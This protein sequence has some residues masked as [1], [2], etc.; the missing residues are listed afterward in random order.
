MKENIGDLKGNLH[1]TQ[2]LFR[3]CD[4]KVYKVL[5]REGRVIVT[6]FSASRA[7]S[8]IAA[9]SQ[10]QTCSLFHRGIKI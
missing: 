3:G 9:V 7:G 5:R 2:S 6:E 1:S 8:V 4:F 10:V